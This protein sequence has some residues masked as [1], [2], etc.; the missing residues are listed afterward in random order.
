MRN[1]SLKFAL[2]CGA[3]AAMLL[4]AGCQTMTPKYEAP[5]PK[6][7]DFAAEMNKFNAQFPNDKATRYEDVSIKFN[8]DQKIDEKGHCHD[9]SQFP[10]TIILQL[11]AAGKV[12]RSMTDVEN[13]KAECFRQ[14]Y[15]SVQFPAPPIA[16][17]RKAILLQ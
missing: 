11:D 3:L 2:K 7:P 6:N 1:Q 9:K 14:T 8:N 13:S 10:V 15:A 5:S 4:A 16:P 12:T 17:Y